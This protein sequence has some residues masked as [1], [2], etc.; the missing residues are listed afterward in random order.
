MVKLF[1]M[2]VRPILLYVTEIWR[3]KSSEQIVTV[4][5]RFY[6]YILNCLRCI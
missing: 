2:L 3:A 5:Q 6:N 4:Q 1:D